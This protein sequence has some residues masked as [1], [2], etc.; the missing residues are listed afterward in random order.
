MA[1]LR[2][3]PPGGLKPGQGVLQSRPLGVLKVPLAPPGGATLGAAL[4]VPARPGVNRDPLPLA[5]LPLRHAPHHPELNASAHKAVAEG[6]FGL[7]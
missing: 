3:S 7:L 4:A 1:A 6:F 2:S 5:R